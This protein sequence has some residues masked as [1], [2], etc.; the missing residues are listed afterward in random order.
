MHKTN[1]QKNRYCHKSCVKEYLE[2]SIGGI[3][4]FL[5]NRWTIQPLM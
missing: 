3:T 4:A 5:R 1:L 2:V